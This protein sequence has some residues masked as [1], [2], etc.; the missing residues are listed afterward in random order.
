MTARV[1]LYLCETCDPSAFAAAR[2]G[3]QAALDAAGLHADVHA[4]PCMNACADPVSLALQA[5]GRATYFFAGV[6]P[7]AD[8]AD[9][10]ATVALYLGSADGWIEDATGCGRLRHCLRGRVPAL[11]SGS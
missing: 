2:T 10:V 11:N 5:S 3:L 7:I 6:D 1:A 4:Q 8:R 9:I